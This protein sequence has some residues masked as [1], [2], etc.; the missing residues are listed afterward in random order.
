VKEEQGEKGAA[1]TGTLPFSKCALSSYKENEHGKRQWRRERE[2]GG[3][4]SRGKAE[5]VAQKSST[6]EESREEMVTRAWSDV[7][8]RG[9]EGRTGGGRAGKKD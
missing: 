6:K 1:K 7:W 8:G 2:G 4:D 9:R 5:N 3:K